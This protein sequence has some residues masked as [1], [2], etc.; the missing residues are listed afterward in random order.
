MKF[1][2]NFGSNVD[3]KSNND[4]L[5][6]ILPVSFPQFCSWFCTLVSTCRTLRG[7]PGI[8]L[9]LLPECDKAH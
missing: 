9:R 1:R 3:L 2:I 4:A 5:P 6:V 7:T 8:S